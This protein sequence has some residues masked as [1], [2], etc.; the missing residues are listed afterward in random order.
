M[1]ELN[2]TT[3]FENLQKAKWPLGVPVNRENPVPLDASSVVEEAQL[4]NYIADSPVAY[5]G[6]QVV[7][8]NDTNA[9]P[10]LLQPDGHTT[11]TRGDNG[12]DSV[13]E[14]NIEQLAFKSDL[15][16][17]IKVEKQGRRAEDT[18]IR[19][20]LATA[21]LKLQHQAAL[22]IGGSQYI[23]DTSSESPVWKTLDGTRTLAFGNVAVSRASIEIRGAESDFT[24]DNES[25][26]AVSDTVYYFVASKSYDKHTAF[27]E[28]RVTSALP[29]SLFDLA[30]V[31]QEF[32]HFYIFD[33]LNYVD[34]QGQLDT[35]KSL[36][37]VIT[38]LEVNTT[39]DSANGWTLTEK[40]ELGEL[41][42][43]EL[44]SL[45]DILD[46]LKYAASNL[47]TITEIADPD[48]LDYQLN[49]NLNA[50]LQGLK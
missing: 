35:S 32:G 49:I 28:F 23:L 44:S 15:D 14:T 37:E 7:A 26:R 50:L 20:E 36:G 27:A 41:H 17:Q 24:T 47:I 9:T 25:V 43:T 42:T 29:V 5:P 21:S 33:S 6:Q 8:L 11:T 18:N 38:S 48:D 39:D 16:Y 40:D 46:T 22:I 3:L 1:A 31:G 4:N 12:T 13:S 45:L 2:T 30:A 34:T 10:F 19:T